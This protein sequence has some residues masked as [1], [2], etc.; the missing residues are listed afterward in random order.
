M[1]ERFNYTKYHDTDDKW[2]DSAV[3][4]NLPVSEVIAEYRRV[5][6]TEELIYGWCVWRRAMDKY[7][8]IKQAMG[9]EWSAEHSTQITWNI[10]HDILEA[11]RENDLMDMWYY[12]QKLE[13]PWRQS[14]DDYAETVDAIY[15][16][17]GGSIEKELQMANPDVQKLFEMAAANEERKREQKEPEKKK[18]GLFHRHKGR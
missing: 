12:R 9:P 15:E 2:D 8:R 6:K 14:F 18:K 7:K 13:K 3:I 11:C 16:Q 10:E 5:G 4:D 17:F 1:S